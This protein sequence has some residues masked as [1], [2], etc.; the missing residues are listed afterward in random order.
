[1]SLSQYEFIRK[2]EKNRNWEIFFF[3]FPIH[4]HYTT[5]SVSRCFKTVDF[6]HQLFV[7][8]V[9]H[10]QYTSNFKS[11]NKVK[12]V[13]SSAVILLKFIRPN[14]VAISKFQRK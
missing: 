7:L 14:C 8:S 3:F 2:F 1:M 6:H 13:F 12:I 4:L 10:R 11:V 5:M 9:H